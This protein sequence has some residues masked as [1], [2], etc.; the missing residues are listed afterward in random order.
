MLDKFT[1]KFGRKY[2]KPLGYIVEPSA[3]LKYKHRF[4]GSSW[5]VFDEKKVEDG[6]V[7]LFVL[8]MSDPKLLGIDVGPLKEL[9]ICSYINS[10]VWVD[11]Q[12]YKIDEKA[13]EVFLVKKNPI[14][15]NILDYEDRLPNPLPEK[16]IV[17][18]GMQ[19]SEY[20][21]DEESYWKITDDFL[22][23]DSFFR[24][25]GSPLWL[26]KVEYVECSCHSEM[27][28]I[29]SIGY[30]GWDNSFQYINDFPFFIGEAALYIYFCKN[31][32]ELKV[33][34]QSS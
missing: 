23:G 33:F 26:E 22:G 4:G 31:C 7:L 27:C 8:D 12:I 19:N 5:K 18:R 15:P 13:R 30:E 25:A 9:P 2:L 6:P 3:S 34:S 29:M 28:H 32:L 1:E 24:V 20:P 16:E 11:E 17:L 21:I 14:E 10:D